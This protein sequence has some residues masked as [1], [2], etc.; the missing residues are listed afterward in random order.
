MN[1]KDEIRVLLS[2]I[3]DETIESLSEPRRELILLLKE[4]LLDD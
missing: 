1:K 3:D 4:R 2:K